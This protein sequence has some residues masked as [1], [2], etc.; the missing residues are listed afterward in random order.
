MG[1]ASPSPPRSSVD[2]EAHPIPPRVLFL[3]KRY[4]D[5]GDFLCVEAKRMDVAGDADDRDPAQLVP[6][7]P[8]ETPADGR[9]ARHGLAHERFVHDG[10]RKRAVSVSIFEP[11]PFEKLYLHDAKIV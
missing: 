11:S 7:R 9:C 2:R 1:R 3:T 5:R 6:P 10:D 8:T 4:V